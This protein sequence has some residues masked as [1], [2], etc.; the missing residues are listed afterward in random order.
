MTSEFVLF[1]SNPSLNHIKIEKCLP[2]FATNTNIFTLLFKELETD[3]KSFIFAV[4]RLT[5]D[6]VTSNLISL[7]PPHPILLIFG[8]LA[9][10]FSFIQQTQRS[11]AIIKSKVKIKKQTIKFSVLCDISS[12][13]FIIGGFG[14]DLSLK[15]GTGRDSQSAASCPYQWQHRV[16]MHESFGRRSHFE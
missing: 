5:Y 15:A 6:H 4:C 16:W 3:G 7:I 12:S 8:H 11:L 1:S 14:A 13:K 9:Q 2:L 10:F